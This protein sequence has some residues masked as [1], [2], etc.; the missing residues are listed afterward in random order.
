[1]IFLGL[2]DAFNWTSNRLPTF[3]RS[4]R[5]RKSPA[6]GTVLLLLALNLLNYLDR[7]ILPGAQPLIQKDFHATDQQMGALTTALFLFYMFA[8]PCS[9]WLGDWVRRKPL[10]ITGAILWSVAT[11]GTAFVHTYWSLYTRRALVGVGEA[12]FGIYGPAVLADFYPER[13][14]NRILSIFYLAIPVG[15]ALGYL[16]GGELGSLWGW[17]KPFLI[18]AI[19][20]LIVAALYGV[21]GRE[22][23]RGA[24][25]RYR[26]AQMRIDSWAAFRRFV[27]ARLRIFKNPAFLTSTFG[28]AAITFALGGISAWVP[29]FLHRANGLSVAN[30][31]LVVGAITVID[32]IGGTIT[33]GWIAHRWQRTDHRALYLISFWSVV[34]TIPFG[35]LVFFGPHSTTIPALF[36]AEFFIF[37]NTGPLN[38]AIVNSVQGAVRATAISINLFCIHA[39]GDTFS[40]QII[41]AISDRSTLSIGLGATLV[42]L[43]IACWI[44]WYGARFAPPYAEAQL[45]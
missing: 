33:G 31:S 36:L 26:T 20:G 19:P 45:P 1:V 14:R 34:F 7:Y 25:D 6:L 13:D 21:W 39:F 41:G 10:I 15:A 8:A 38:A 27:K 17:R 11:L 9:G 16:A 5:P 43:V 28:L 18:C 12:T 40:P 22:P 37:V 24:K 2:R 44:L 30:A 4:L 3:L 23:E 29:T 42:S 32:G 35:V